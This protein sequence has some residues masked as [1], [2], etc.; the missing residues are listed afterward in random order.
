ML[1]CMELGE[2]ASSDRKEN[3]QELVEM[4]SQA[5]RVKESQEPPRCCGSKKYPL[6]EQGGVPGDRHGV[7]PLR[8]NGWEW[9]NCNPRSQR[10]SQRV[11]SPN[12]FAQGTQRRKKKKMLYLSYYHQNLHMRRRSGATSEDICSRLGLCPLLWLCLALPSSSP[13]HS[14]LTSVEE[15][16]LYRTPGEGLWL[17]HCELCTCLRTNHGAVWKVDKD[18]SRLRK[19][20]RMEA[21]EERKVVWGILGR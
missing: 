15:S 11:V 12:W 17:A 13:R 16:W 21:W 1:H 8:R 20:R 2:T 4:L 18:A 7:S 19:K 14:R 6:Q 5:V 10:L 3:Q 9:A